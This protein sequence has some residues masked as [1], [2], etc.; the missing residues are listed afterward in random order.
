[1]DSQKNCG[2][3]WFMNAWKMPE[4]TLAQIEGE[5]LHRLIEEMMGDA[6]RFSLPEDEEILERDHG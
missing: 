5:R 6:K 1:M 3:K 4:K 2:R